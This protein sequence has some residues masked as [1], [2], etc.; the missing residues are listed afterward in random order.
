MN[1]STMMMNRNSVER[2]LP[3]SEMSVTR[4]YFKPN[5]A[6]DFAYQLPVNRCCYLSSDFTEY[7]IK[8]PWLVSACHIHPIIVSP[9]YILLQRNPSTSHSLNSPIPPSFRAK[10]V[11]HRFW[12]TFLTLHQIYRSDNSLIIIIIIISS[13]RGLKRKK[14]QDWLLGFYDQVD[15]QSYCLFLIFFLQLSVHWD[16]YK[17]I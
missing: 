11:S 7:D 1:R 8:A 16:E 12:S 2:W 6:W 9:L 4:I 10:F 17:K 5:F 13:L 3:R 14:I 15:E